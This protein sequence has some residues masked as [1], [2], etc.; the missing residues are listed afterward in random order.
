MDFGQAL[1]AWAVRLS[2]VAYVGALGCGIPGFFAVAVSERRVRCARWLWTLGSL[3]MAVHVVAAFHFYHEWS[4]SR[5]FAETAKQTE[6]LLGWAFGGGIF[7]SYLFVAAWV[8]D[9]FWWW[10][11]PDSY[12]ARS[13][14]IGWPV[15]AYFAFIA[16]NG[17]VVFE[18]GATRWGGIAAILVLAIVAYRRYRQA[19]SPGD[20]S[21]DRSDPASLP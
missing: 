13:P 20:R 9:A 3:G 4:H 18:G 6:E 8:V 11:A 10:C 19:H 21:D 1:T 7:F 5:A 16:F 17:A 2:L 14:W 15:H 12:T